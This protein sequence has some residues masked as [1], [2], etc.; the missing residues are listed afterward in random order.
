M[1]RIDRFD[2][3]RETWHLPPV[4]NKPG[5]SLGEVALEHRKKTAGQTALL[6]HV[7]Q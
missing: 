4:A 1:G 5:S 2:V 3:S 6:F 7:E